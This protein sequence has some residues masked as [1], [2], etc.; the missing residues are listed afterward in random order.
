M[1]K[2]LNKK[3]C[4][5]GMILVIMVCFTPTIA[6]AAVPGKKK[7]DKCHRGIEHHRSCLGIWRDT[8]LGL[9]L[10]LTQKQIKL[11]RDADFSFRDRHLALK[12]QLDRFHLELDKTVSKDIID[13][14]TVIKA[15]QQ[16]SD[17][18]GKLF[19]Q[20]ME[21]RLALGKILNTDQT[22]Q[23]GLFNLNPKHRHLK[24]GKKCPSKYHTKEP[25]CS[26]APA[27]PRND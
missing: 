10:G 9:K 11:I 15:A 21:S 16:I 2:T 26:D 3:I 12:A 17:V 27:A 19:V 22:K 23:L 6:S 25:A 13:E 24:P 4:T 1:T 14:Q 20:R 8:E 18:K 5:I 7:I